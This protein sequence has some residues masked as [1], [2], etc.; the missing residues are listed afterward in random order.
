[1]EENKRVVF[2][3]DT[4]VWINRIIEILKLHK[5]CYPERYSNI[6]TN[7]TKSYVTKEKIIVAYQDDNF[8]NPIC[9]FPTIWLSEKDDEIAKIILSEKE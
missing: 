9:E 4:K 5:K 8:D 7:K 3:T 6:D 2:S 1:M